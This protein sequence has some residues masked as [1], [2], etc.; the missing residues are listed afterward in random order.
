MPKSEVLRWVEYLAVR[1]S[2]MMNEEREDRSE[3]SL[4]SCPELALGYAVVLRKEK[5][6]ILASVLPNMTWSR[7]W[8]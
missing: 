6:S 2:L 1:C 3:K 4:L 8:L 5:I 7:L